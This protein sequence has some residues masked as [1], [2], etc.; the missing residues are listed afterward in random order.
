LGPRAGKLADGGI[1]HGLGGYEPGGPRT[2]SRRDMTQL[3]WKASAL[4]TRWGQDLQQK[5]A[6][7]DDCD[8]DY[9]LGRRTSDQELGRLYARDGGNGRNIREAGREAEKKIFKRPF[10]NRP[11]GPIANKTGHAAAITF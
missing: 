4:T 11:D 3:R 6:S 1:R 2:I 5:R 8:A 9:N 7:G 10:A